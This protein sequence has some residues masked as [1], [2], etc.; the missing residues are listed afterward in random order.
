MSAGKWGIAL[1]MSAWFVLSCGISL[2]NRYIFVKVG[3]TFPIAL[4][5]FHMLAQSVLSLMTL[6]CSAFIQK[7]SMSWQIYRSCIIP[8][9]IVQSIEIV[10]NNVG[11][12]HIPVSFVQTL[13]S[14]TPL[15]AALL[16]WMLLGKSLTRKAFL[17]LIPI[18]VGVALSSFQELSFHA[19][20]FFAIIFSCFLTAGK[21]TLVSKLFAGKLKLDPV[22]AIYFMSPIGFLFLLP[23]ACLLEGSSLKEWL[24][25]KDRDA[26]DFL[27]VGSTG[28]L[29]YSLVLSIFLLLQR[30]SAVS[31]AVAG[32]CKVI[33]IIISSLVFFR[34][35]MTALGGLGCL[36]A[37][38]GGACYG[39]TNPKFE[40]E[41][42][43]AQLQE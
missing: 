37:V 9:A 4:T 40:V 43:E 41:E 8:V 38:S 5:T 36:I 18:S 33:L 7:Q 12:R 39:L 29:A 25:S 2:L 28:I 14:L 17:S 22:S 19:G 21:L 35:P 32:N 24:F 42:T 3:F 15:S 30:T 26:H 31:V 34:N 23:V 1:S 10:F 27:T 13:R 20:G 16:A 6:H 11:L